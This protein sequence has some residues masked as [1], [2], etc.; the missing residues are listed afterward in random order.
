VCSRD[1]C[2]SYWQSPWPGHGISPNRHPVDRYRAV[3]RH[4]AHNPSSR[5]SGRCL[6][7]QPSHTGLSGS[8]S[9]LSFIFRSATRI[10]SS[11][12]SS[13]LS[14]SGPRI[15]PTRGWLPSGARAGAGDCPPLPHKM[16]IA[17]QRC[18]LGF[19]GKGGGRPYAV[20]VRRLLRRASGISRR[21]RTG[22]F[23]T[24]CA[25]AP[26]SA[27]PCVPAVS[28]GRSA[29]PCAGDVPRVHPALHWVPVGSALI[30]SPW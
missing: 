7:S 26:R 9:P 29:A 23:T 17:V 14:V 21:A 22:M 11:T 13:F 28:A 8:H 15:V 27:A 5:Q 16:D 24:L 1:P 10:S 2:P 20:A 4:S 30:G 6:R 18:L 19:V 12:C 3:S 25:R